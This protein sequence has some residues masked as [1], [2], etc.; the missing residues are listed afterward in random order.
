LKT[1]KTLTKRS[2]I[3]T[4]IKRIR[5]E[6][7]IPKIKRIFFFIWERKEG[8]KKKKWS[9]VINCPSTAFTCHTRRKKT[10]WCFHHHG[11]KTGLA[12][13]RHRTCHQ[14]GTNTSHALMCDEHA[15]T[16]FLNKKLIIQQF[17]LFLL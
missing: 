12:T 7:E 2:R 10:W 11:G 13:R 3:R 6:I 9:L 1:N 4:K 16:T 8:E 15:P 17:H 5:N 14:N